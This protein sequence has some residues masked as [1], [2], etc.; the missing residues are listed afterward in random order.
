M[1]SPQRLD[2]DISKG[3]VFGPVVFTAVDKNGNAFDLTNW[4][5][6]AKSTND[7]RQLN[8]LQ[9]LITNAVAGQIMIQLTQQ[10]T[11]SFSVGRNRWDLILQRPTG[12][13]L[14]PYYGGNLTVSEAVSNV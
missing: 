5:V 9:P 1:T 11:D 4:Q 7:F 6:F 13:R 14:A 8:D 2:L 3:S 10:Q 12:E